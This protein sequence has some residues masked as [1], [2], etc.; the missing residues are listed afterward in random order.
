[1][2]S[3]ILAPCGHEKAAVDGEGYGAGGVGGKI[4]KEL[5]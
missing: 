3:K 2:K 4:K 1:L 5:Y